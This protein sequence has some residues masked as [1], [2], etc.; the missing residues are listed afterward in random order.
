MVD[1]LQSDE[2]TQS[3]HFA[4]VIR[5]FKM[6]DRRENL[7]WALACVLWWQTRSDRAQI[8][9]FCWKKPIFINDRK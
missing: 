2:P 8:F 3:S 1:N 5:V 9:S 7:A 6:A 4:S